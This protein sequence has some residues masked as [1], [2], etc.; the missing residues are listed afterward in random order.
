MR[1]RQGDA[2]TPCAK[3]RHAAPHGD[4]PGSTISGTIMAN[5]EN[6]STPVP[7]STLSDGRTVTYGPSERHDA[8]HLL[9]LGQVGRIQEHGVLRLDGLRGVLGV[10]L[11]DHV[12]LSDQAA[13]LLVGDR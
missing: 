8:F 3:V 11:N 4:L 6:Y 2:T 7:A 9:G 12:G 13:Q 10:P 1:V 5:L